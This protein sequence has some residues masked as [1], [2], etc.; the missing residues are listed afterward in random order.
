MLQT[1][2]TIELNIICNYYIT[3]RPSLMIKN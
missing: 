1:I 3:F 2:K